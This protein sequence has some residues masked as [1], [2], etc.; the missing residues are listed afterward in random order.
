MPTYKIEVQSYTSYD[1][2]KSLYKCPI[3]QPKSKRTKY[4]QKYKGAHTKM[5]IRESK[6]ESSRIDLELVGLLS[7]ISQVLSGRLHFVPG[8]GI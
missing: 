5:E 7:Q 8:L 3:S 2:Q 6:K 1:I 4:N